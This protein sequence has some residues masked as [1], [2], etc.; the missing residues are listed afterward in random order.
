MNAETPAELNAAAF[1]FIKENPGATRDAIRAALDVDAGRLEMALR[2]LG[3]CDNVRYVS[4]RFAGVDG[5]YTK[6]A[7]PQICAAERRARMAYR[8]AASQR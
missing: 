6:S 1:A 3:N 5:Y 4:D 8:I 2:M 7:A